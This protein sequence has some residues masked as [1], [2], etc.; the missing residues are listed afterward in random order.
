LHNW[1]EWWI[2]NFKQLWVSSS[3]IRG[4]LECSE[5]SE[6]VHPVI[7][8]SGNER[9][10]DFT[11]EKDRIQRYVNEIIVPS[12]S[13]PVHST[14]KLK[15]VAPF[16]LGS[17]NDDDVKDKEWKRKWM[18]PHHSFIHYHA[19][20]FWKK[21]CDII[22]RRKLKI[23]SVTFKV[24]KSVHHHT[25]QINQP[26]RRSNFSSLLLDIYVQLNMFRASSR[27]SSG[28]QQLR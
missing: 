22:T 27:S 19:D 5:L 14:P 26:T 25:I 28:A 21:D 3:F 2:G 8:W 7:Y 15:S 23:R 17:A 10:I 4:N 9:D 11:A 6:G 24:C 18:T 1:R 13:N 20:N 12:I 16:S